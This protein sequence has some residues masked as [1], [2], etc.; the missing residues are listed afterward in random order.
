MPAFGTRPDP[1]S[2][3]TGRFGGAGE[4]LTGIL[5]AG[6]LTEVAGSGPF[7]AIRA[8]SRRSRPRAAP[9]RPRSS[10]T[11]PMSRMGP[12]GG[13]HRVQPLP[14]RPVRTGPRTLWGLPV[15]STDAIAKGTALVGDFRKAI[16]WDRS[17]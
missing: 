13:E 3:S 5:N 2:A 7:Y 4:D 1:E 6:I 17:R 14:R 10:R 12:R 16:L 9:R 15:I 8:G 11:R